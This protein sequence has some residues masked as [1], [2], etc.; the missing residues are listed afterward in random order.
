MRNFNLVL[1]CP[2]PRLGFVIMYTLVPWFDGIE[3]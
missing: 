2:S 3:I 1:A